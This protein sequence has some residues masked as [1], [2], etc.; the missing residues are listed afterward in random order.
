M[1]EECT[2]FVANGNTVKLGYDVMKKLKI[3]VV[4]YKR[5]RN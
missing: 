1:A 5:C 2:V 4:T 3:C